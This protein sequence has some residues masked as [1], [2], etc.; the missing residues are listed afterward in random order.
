MKN[1]ET[2]E[3]FLSR[4]FNGANLR[5]P[6]MLLVLAG[7]LICVMLLLPPIQNL[8]FHI[9]DAYISRRGAGEMIESRLKSFLTM[10][11]FGLMVFIFAFCCLFSKTITLF[12][13]NTKNTK[14]I[15]GLTIG[16]GA[17]LTGYI[18][19]FSYQ[20]GWQWLNSDSSSEM[21]LGKLLAQENAFVSRNWHYSTEIRLIYQTLFTMPLFKLFKG[22]ENWALIRTFVI[23]LNNIILILSY[24]FMAK[25]IKI[26]TKWIWITSLFLIMPI[27]PG[28]WE[29]VTFGGYYIFFIAQIFCY[30]GF[31]IRFVNHTGN[32]KTLFP[33]FIFFTIFSFLLGI[34]G[35]RSLLCISI[36]LLIVCIWLFLRITKNKI[37]FLFL[38]CYGFVV[39]FIG[40]A[41]NYLLKFKYSFQSFDNM[42]LADLY[43]SFSSKLFQCIVC[44]ADFFGFSSGNSLL[45]ASGLLG[46]MAIIGTT[47]LFLSVYR[48][49]YKMSLQN[50]AIDKPVEHQ[51]LIA[52]FI[53]SVIVN[54]FVFIIVDSDITGRYF[55]P[56]MVLYIPL[57]AILFEYTEKLYGNLKRIALVSGIVLFIIA[58]GYLNFQSIARQDLN[59]VRKGYIQYLLDNRLNFGFATFWNANV[60]T[61]LT[62]GKIEFVGLNPH[63]INP[64]KGGDF[65]IHNWLSMKKYSDPSYHSG[66]TF[67]LLTCDEW[68]KAQTSVRSFA[69]LQP[70]YTDTNFIIIRYPS[71]E[72]IHLEVLGH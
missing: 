55:I 58:Q 45:S 53:I 5:K 3:I 71:T 4:I 18:G 28:Y 23:L 60:T 15:I 69:L 17:L 27:T 30:L 43:T 34:Q 25:Q 70:N 21:V 2:P 12:F 56:F 9:A 61:E 66:E 48:S 65:R 14:L 44:L 10:A 33:G 36:P 7:T 62:N 24:F 19:F 26:Q 20:Y 6:V 49:F 67:L 52:F 29:I 40:F 57:C 8:F 31:F 11:F 59:T 38:G 13:E 22:H 39:C 46:V 50:S 42:Q 41:A 64:E 35:I 68:E 32:I 16:T 72:I 51:F 63:S 54:I 47:L 1:I 37:V